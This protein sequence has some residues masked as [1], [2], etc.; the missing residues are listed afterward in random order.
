MSAAWLS[1]L[2]ARMIAGWLIEAAWLGAC[3]T[4]KMN[5]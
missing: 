5:G 1:W 4:V 3:R 2:S